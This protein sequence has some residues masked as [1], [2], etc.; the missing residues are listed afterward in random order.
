[1]MK[2]QADA[3]GNPFLHAQPRE[4]GSVTGTL[5]K[6]PSTIVAVEVDWR[7]LANGKSEI[8]PAGSLVQVK[9]AAGRIQSFLFAEEGSVQGP[10]QTAIQLGVGLG[11]WAPNRSRKL[12]RVSTAVIALATLTILGF[13]GS[14]S[15]ELGLWSRPARIELLVTL[16]LGW[17]LLCLIAIYGLG[18]QK[19][20]RRQS[21]KIPAPR[22]PLPGS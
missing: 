7:F 4:K 9:G 15:P 12:S 5:I 1:M 3:Y 18:P 21:L 2:S 8:V 13:L 19:S 22:E 14:I 17:A 11:A 20:V 6:I 16:G 10:L